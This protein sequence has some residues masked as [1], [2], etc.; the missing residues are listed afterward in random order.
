MKRVYLGDDT[1]HFEYC[2]FRYSNIDDLIQEAKKYNISIGENVHIGDCV[3]IGTNVSIGSN[4]IVNRGVSIWSDVII[5]NDVTIKQNCIINDNITINS[6]TVIPESSI[7][8]FPVCG[9]V[10]NVINIDNLYGHKNTII[11]TEDDV[12]I[13]FDS[14]TRSLDNWEKEL[15]KFQDY[16]EQG[17]QIL[18]AFIVIKNIIKTLKEIR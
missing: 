15:Q 6:N 2:M 18:N 4:S 11:L 17:Q 9:N 16:S 12:F 8:N 7:I 3:S 13:R 1:V 10:I 5:C 14:D